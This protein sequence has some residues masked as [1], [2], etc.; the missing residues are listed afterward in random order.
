MTNMWGADADAL[1]RVGAQLE[2]AGVDLRTRGRR[3]QH[4]LDAS[5]WQGRSADR[6][7]H[8]FAQVHLRA[9]EEAA[10]FLDQAKETLHLNAEQQRSA[11]STGAGASHPPIDRVNPLGPVLGNILDHSTAH[12]AGKDDWGFS[13]DKGV[14]V[15]RAVIEGERDGR[16]DF[17]AGIAATGVV[18]GSILGGTA[19]ASAGVGIGNDG[20][21]AHARANAEADLAEVHASG[22]LGTDELGL[23]AKGQ[24]KIDA[25][26]DAAGRIG[27]TT[28]GLFAMAGVGAFAGAEASGKL[29]ADVGGVKPNV[30]GTVSA[31]I[32]AHARA[33]AEFGV[34]HVKATVDLGLVVGIGG[35]VKFDVDVEPKRVAHNVATAWH[36]VNPFD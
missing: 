3:L 24:A 22:R 32:G 4:G 6:F 26:A 36:N 20:V 5:P 7:R 12:F 11:S 9:I 8:D 13:V 35:G 15:H 10:R 29:G 1:D 14:S 16:H 31:G 28:G 21:D 27:A 18:G 23:E 19:G 17:G 33:D 34:D 25:R 2:R 30:T